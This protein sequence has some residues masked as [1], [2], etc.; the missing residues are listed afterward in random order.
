M[1]NAIVSLKQQ[2]Q[3]AQSLKDMFEI[4]SFSEKWISNYEKTT[5]K[6]DGTIMWERH[7]VD[8]LSAVQNNNALQ[9]CD[10][11]S[12]YMAAMQSAASGL[13]M[14]EGMSGIIPYKDKAQFQIFANGRREQLSWL[15]HIQY[16]N[17]P[18]VVRADDVF[19]YQAGE[20]LRI[21]KHIP[22]LNS[23]AEIIAVYVVLDT[24]SGKKT[25]LMHRSEVIAIRDNY[26]TQYKFYMQKQEK[27]EIKDWMDK[28][29]WISNE[30]EAFKKTIIKRVWKVQPNKSARLKE[31]D[32]FESYDD[33]DSGKAPQDEPIDYGM[34]V[35]EESYSDY[36]E[37]DVIDES[38]E[39]ET[40]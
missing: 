37:A 32:K 39:E 30:A 36:E 3:Q 12:I 24:T 10:R 14:S 26:S 27:G 2:L 31:M 1:G 13:S 6:K 33:V 5:G 40:F 34:D 16:V 29:M 4:P 8:F 20:D 19:E 17:E 23:D 35:A 22:K 18:V 7:K 28:P 38:T 9:K 21:I 11:L 25:Y 15:P